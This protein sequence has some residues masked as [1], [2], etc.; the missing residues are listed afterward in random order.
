MRNNK[1]N[2]CTTRHPADGFF[3]MLKAELGWTARRKTHVGIPII[4]SRIWSKQRCD[5]EAN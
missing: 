5:F 1:Y 2:L 4:I 3:R